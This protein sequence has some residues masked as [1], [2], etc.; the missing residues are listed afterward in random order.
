[1]PIGVS[2]FQTAKDEALLAIPLDEAETQQLRADWVKGAQTGENA[3][4]ERTRLSVA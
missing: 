3:G 2:Q 1:M 4:A